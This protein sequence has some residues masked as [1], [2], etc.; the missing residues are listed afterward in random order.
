MYTSL[1][2]RCAVLTAPFILQVAYQVGSVHFTA[3]KGGDARL[4]L[5][6][7]LWS[8]SGSTTGSNNTWGS[9]RR[10]H[11]AFPWPFSSSREVLWPWGRLSFESRLLCS[12]ERVKG[13]IC[14]LRQLPADHQYMLEEVG[15]IEARLE[16]EER[17]S[18]GRTGWVALLR[19]S[20]AEM[21]TSSMRYRLYVPR[22]ENIWRVLTTAQR[23]NC[24]NV[25][26]PELV[27]LHLHQV[28][29][30]PMV[31]ES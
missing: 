8:G 7:D 4:T 16:E 26:V 20:T 14:Y 3:C 18:G 19:G 28:R 29:Y 13:N 21:K 10:S 31:E 12:G 5:L 22:S 27:R 6:T 2:S 1:L 24:W 23:H 11:S 9:T 25:Y 17:L 30:A 15:R